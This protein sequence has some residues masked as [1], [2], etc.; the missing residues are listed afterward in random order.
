LNSSAFAKLIKGKKTRKKNAGNYSKKS[1][2]PL[3]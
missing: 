3:A 1:R 2:K